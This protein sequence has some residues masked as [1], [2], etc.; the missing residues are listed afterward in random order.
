MGSWPT[1]DADITVLI[2]EIVECSTRADGVQVVVRVHGGG[3]RGMRSGDCNGLLFLS[4][5]GAF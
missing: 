1:V 4:R 3:W 2:F 5:G